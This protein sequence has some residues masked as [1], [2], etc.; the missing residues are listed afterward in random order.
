MDL[1][2][3][4]FFWRIRSLLLSGGLF[5]QTE[6]PASRMENM[7]GDRTGESHHRSFPIRLFFRRYNI[8]L[9][10]TFHLSQARSWTVVPTIRELSFV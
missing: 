8:S 5:G 7:L 4:D 2:R 3:S 9:S 1:P 10:L 6:L